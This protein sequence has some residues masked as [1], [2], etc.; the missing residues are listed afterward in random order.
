MKRFVAKNSKF[1]VYIQGVS[2]A[3]G[4]LWRAITSTKV[5]QFSWFFHC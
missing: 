4:Q 5:Y 1:S 2:E 3:P